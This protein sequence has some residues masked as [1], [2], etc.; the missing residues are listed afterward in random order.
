MTQCDFCGGTL[1]PK[2]LPYFD[3]PW[4]DEVY[5]F[6][7]VPALVC[8][9]CGEA[10]LEAAVSQ[11]MDQFLQTTAKPQPLRYDRIPVFSLEQVSV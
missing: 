4:G 2:I 7:H 10:Y 11:A 3:Q 5:R 1:H 9:Q 8:S 6:E